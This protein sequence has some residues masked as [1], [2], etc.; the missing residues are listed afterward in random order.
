MIGGPQLFGALQ[1]GLLRFYPRGFRA[2]FEREMA[3]VF[4][5]LAGEVVGTKLLRI[6][7]RELRDWPRAVLRE[8]WLALKQGRALR[9]GRPL[10]LSLIA[11]LDPRRI[12]M[13]T[14][15][16]AHLLRPEDKRAAAVAG[17]PLVL[18]GL[19]IGINAAVYQGPWYAVPPWRLYLSIGLGLAPMALIGLGA[20][21]AIVRRLPI[22]GWS[23]LGTAFMGV[24]LFVKTLVEEMADEGRP[25]TT[26]AGEAAILVL[27]LAIG[28]ALVAAAAWRGWRQAG[29]V[30]LGLA[31]T[32]GLSLFMAV[33]AAPFNRTDLAL[34]AAPL[35]AL[36]AWLIYLYA[37]G[38]D[39][40]RLA[41]F[42]G[43]GALNL[44]VIALANQVW[45]VWLDAHGSVSPIIPLLVLTLLMLLVGPA[46]ALILRPLQRTAA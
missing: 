33:T 4:S 5:D 10:R 11:P 8:H 23:W 9:S 13:D 41:L 43:M 45:M 36:M 46:A 12:M 17:L 21:L 30:S 15:D 40:L 29:L 37:R 24:V 22:W 2:E 38:S 19:G 16:Q 27:F 32:L 1:R 39:R 14:M 44:G 34:L 6:F 18:L 26:P 3:E 25:L 7:L 20:L 31:G 42:F 28:G 35:S